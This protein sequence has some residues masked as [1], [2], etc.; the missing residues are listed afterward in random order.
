M[1]KSVL[2]E[3]RTTTSSENKVEFQLFI[4]AELDFFKGHF[5]EQPVLPGVTQLDWA[6]QLACQHFNYQV[7]IAQLEV[8]KFQQILLPNSLVTLTI[9][10][11]P[12]KKKL[13]FQ[14]HQGDM[15]FASGR[16]VIGSPK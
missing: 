14:Y 7:D 8:L 5:P 1:I 2:P 3:I 12:A 4:S 15:R 9:E 13:T 16:I 10:H 11:K 6:V